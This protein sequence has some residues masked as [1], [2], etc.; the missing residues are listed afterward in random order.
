MKLHKK[1]AAIALAV[2]L[3]LVCAACGGTQ[4][5][6]NSEY[7]TEGSVIFQKDGVKVTTA[8]F[9]MDP[10]PLTP[11]LSSGWRLKTRAVRKPIWA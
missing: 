6:G 4:S 2:M 10:L 11:P 3:A 1:V 7:K 5:A 8:G 9:D